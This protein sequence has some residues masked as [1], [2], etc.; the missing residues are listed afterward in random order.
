VAV[1]HFMNGQ[2]L[3]VAS[4][5]FPR[6]RRGQALVAQASRF[7]CTGTGVGVGEAAALTAYYEFRE[8][9]HFTA[10]IR[11]THRTS[12]ADME[13]RRFARCLAAAL[14]QTSGAQAEGLDSYPFAVVPGVELTTGRLVEVPLMMTTLRDSGTD[15]RFMPAT[16]S[17]GMA[18]HAVPQQCLSGALL[19]FLERQ[20]LLAAWL[21]G[22]CQSYVELRS[23]PDEVGNGLRENLAALMAR[24]RVYVVDISLNFSA[25]AFLAL[26]EA[27][28]PS[29]IMFA[30]GVSAKLDPV[31]ALNKALV[32]LWQG[33]CHMDLLTGRMQWEPDRLEKNYLAANGKG[34]AALFGLR[35]EFEGNLGQLLGRVPAS[36]DRVIKELSAITDNLAYVVGAE[37]DAADLLH[38][39][40]VVSPDCFL[41]MDVTKPLNRVNKFAEA[42]GIT[43]PDEGCRPIPFA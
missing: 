2:Q 21:T 18:V 41:H 10:H 33:Y 17:S 22:A 11:S 1:L 20:C 39:G 25:C 29:R 7:S 34:T 12:L 19:E 31:T 8:R 27:D 42:Y 28:T 30:S 4:D 9:R 37:G 23:V 36:V 24:G 13:D 6:L 38:F 16:D 32:E 40:R 26:Y 15:N 5:L 43:Y 3:A 14:R 35:P